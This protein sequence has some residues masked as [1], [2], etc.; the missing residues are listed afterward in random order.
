MVFSH[1]FRRGI[2][3]AVLLLFLAAPLSAQ[4]ED[5]IAA[6]TGE[7]ATGYLN[8]LAGAIGATLNS[9]LYRSA[10][11][12]GF[13]LT[14]ALEFPVMGLYFGDDDR[15][16]TATTEA[17]FTPE[18]T[19]E[20]PT[21][22]G[23]TKVVIVDGD[24]GT[25]FAFPG[26]FDVGSFAI[27]APQLRV[28][29]VFGTEAMIRFVAVKVG[30]NDLGDI[31]LFGL[32]FRHSISQYMGPIPPVDLAASFFWQSF[33]MGENESGEDLSKT[34]TYSFGLQASKHIPPILTPY[35]GLYYNSYT[36]DVTYESEVTG[37]EDP[38]D[39]TF[40]D[41]YIQ[42]TI[43]IELNLAILNAFVEY[44]VSSYNSLAFG[45]GLGF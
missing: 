39:L 36:M 32:G 16:F 44:N 35:T 4:V 40:D 24:G 27:T 23:D 37:E 5:H 15:T 8:P 18:Q 11:I 10:R 7:N 43:G 19:A 17:G 2:W 38:I 28:G 9:G 26:G 31:S 29:S 42:W 34:N 3:S 25:Q 33:K 30:D 21:V 13:G 45:L 41:G 22:V 6:Y 14:I 1:V 12:P 20:A